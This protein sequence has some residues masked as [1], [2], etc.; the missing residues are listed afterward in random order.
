VAA[1]LKTDSHFEKYKVGLL[2]TSNGMTNPTHMPN[3]MHLLQTLPFLSNKIHTYLK[4]GGHL[5]FGGHI[6]ILKN[7]SIA[8]IAQNIVFYHH[9]KFGASI[10]KPT[11]FFNSY[12][13]NV[14]NTYW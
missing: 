4:N 9:A 8:K 3:F 6:G 13:I 10:T 12:W 1:I 14:I 7:V 11:F 5:G 2:Q